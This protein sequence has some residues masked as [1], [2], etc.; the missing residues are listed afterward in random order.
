MEVKDFNFRKFHDD[1]KRF[2]RE[3]KDESFVI[4]SGNVYMMHSTGEWN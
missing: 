4:E 3:N 1:R 2:L